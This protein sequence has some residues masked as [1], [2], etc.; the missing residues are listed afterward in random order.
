MPWERFRFKGAKVWARVDDE[1]NPAV[2]EGR[3]EIRYREDDERT[4]R[5]AARRV[6]PLDEAPAPPP[7][8]SGVKSRRRKDERRLAT[9]PVPDGILVAHT[10]G[11]C[12]GN[13]GPAGWGA[14]LRWGTH[15]RELSGALGRATSNIAELW[16]IKEALQAVKDRDLPVQLHT[17]STYA[18][19]VLTR[20]WKARANQ[21]LVA[22]LR[23]LVAEFPKLRLVKVEGHAGVP[24][25]E[26]ADELA[27]KAIRR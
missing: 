8:A 23:D 3:V 2:E 17:D 13:P 6:R 26:R 11:A 9:E 14:V 5:A 16:A 4:Y 25:N 20:G 21:E 1:G 27:R 22:E 7:S 24:D 12:S 15:V 18:L 10:D 19:G